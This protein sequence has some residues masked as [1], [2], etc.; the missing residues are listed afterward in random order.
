MLASCSR[1]EVH[2]YLPLSGRD[3]AR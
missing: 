1:E 3:A 2:G